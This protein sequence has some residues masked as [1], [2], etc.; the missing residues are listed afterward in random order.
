VC[1]ILVI[2]LELSKDGP[3]SKPASPRRL[4]MERGLLMVA[5]VSVAFEIAYRLSLH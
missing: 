4:W 2:A 1:F 5:T 3:S